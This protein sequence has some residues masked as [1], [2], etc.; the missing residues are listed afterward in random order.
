MNMMSKVGGELKQGMSA[1]K[2]F[3]LGGRFGRLVAGSVMAS[4]NLATEAVHLSAR[5]AAQAVG[6][7]VGVG[8]GVV[9]GAGLARNMVNAVEVEAARGADASR[10][11]VVEV[12]TWMVSDSDEAE[13]EGAAPENG[14]RAEWPELLAD[15]A[16]TP[17]RSL[18]AAYLSLGAES[19]RIASAT[20]PGKMA[21]DTGLDLL[22]GGPGR[23][24]PFD[25]D[26]RR[27]SFG[28]LARAAIRESLALAEAVVRLAFLDVRPMR[29][30]LEAGLEDMQHLTTTAGM[31]ELLPVPIASESLQEGAQLIVDRAP[32]RFLEA[33][34]ESDG[35]APQPRTILAAAFEDVSNLRVFLVIYPQVLTLI[36]IGVGRQLLSGSITFTELEAFMEGRRISG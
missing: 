25:A 5:T 8:E 10:R 28:A 35:G 12:S 24:T 7:A 1:P 26:E 34:R 23:V 4:T 15:T 32:E 33:L 6:A 30:T 14:D 29:E 9:P 20:R 31:L 3:F 21:V 13:D 16:I 19:I 11:L 18:L 2:E 22:D 17:V 36:G 27:Q